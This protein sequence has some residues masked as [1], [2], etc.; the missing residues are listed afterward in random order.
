MLC[1]W[2]VEL[3]LCSLDK[4]NERLFAGK[5]NAEYQ[6]WKMA[7]EE[8]FEQRKQDLFRFLDLNKDDIHRPTIFQIIQSHGYLEEIGVTLAENYCDYTNLVQHFINKQ[9]YKKALKTMG[10][11]DDVD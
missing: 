1:T 3:K 5:Y 2:I 9:D 4:L 11:V 7:L 8:T 10:K 6:E